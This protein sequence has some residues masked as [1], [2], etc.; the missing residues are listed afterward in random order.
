MQVS[1][2]RSYCLFTSC[3][4]A[5]KFTVSAF[6]WDFA[7][8]LLHL[9]AFHF[10]SSPLIIKSMILMACVLKVWKT[11][12]MWQ[13]GSLRFYHYLGFFFFLLF[14]PCCVMNSIFGLGLLGI[15]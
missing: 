8:S 7:F 11:L 15:L 14:S 2:Q 12:H 6:K 1:L 3:L 4:A 13:G 9:N 5:T 10:V